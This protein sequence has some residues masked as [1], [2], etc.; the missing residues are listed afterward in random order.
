MLVGTKHLLDQ[1]SFSNKRQNQPME[2]I[3]ITQKV[4]S[5]EIVIP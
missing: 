5:K 1:E 2:L 3:I 4:S